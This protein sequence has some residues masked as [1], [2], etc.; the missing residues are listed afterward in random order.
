MRAGEEAGKMEGVSGTLGCSLRALKIGLRTDRDSWSGLIDPFTVRKK[1]RP[2]CFWNVYLILEE[3][4][5]RACRSVFNRSILT[6]RPPLEAGCGWPSGPAL[7]VGG[8]ADP[9]YNSCWNSCV[10][11]GS[12]FP[13]SGTAADSWSV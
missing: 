8:V 3:S 1:R 10:R 6:E 7:P 12:A 13:Q 9:G 2:E 4:E 5:Y 11:K